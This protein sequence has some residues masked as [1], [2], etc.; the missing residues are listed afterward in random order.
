MCETTKKIVVD[1]VNPYG[2][3]K[4]GIED[5]IVAWTKNLDQNLFDLR[6]MHM[7]PGT[8]YL[9]G[10]KKAYFLTEDKKFV[11]ASY[12]ASGYNLLVNHLGPPDICIAATTPMMSLACEKVRSFN[13]LNYRIFSWIHSEISR[14]ETTGNGGVREM[15][16]A[17]Y[18]LTINSSIADDIKRLKP[19]ACIYN[20]GNPI[21]HEIPKDYDFSLCKSDTL[22][23]VGRLSEEKRIDIILEA[24]AK[25]KHKWNLRIIGDGPIR[26]NIESWI[27]TLRL[28]NQVSILGWKDNPLEY[29]KDVTALVAAS[30][31]EGFMIT[32][33]E[34]LA[35]G[36]TVIST[37]N[38][39]T[40]DYISDGI[41]GYF[42]DSDNSDSLAA[43][44][45][46][47]A[48]GT[49]KI[50]SPDVCRHSVERY[51]KTNYFDD[52][53]RIFLD[54]FSKEKELR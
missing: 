31:Y 30:D 22:A 52:L 15:L 13:K 34:A 3:H 44:L 39:G 42:F 26:A 5:V 54:V 45:N 28:N 24:I 37:K 1:I 18:H 46:K 25:S 10:Y 35:M 27:N 20:I 50:P 19:Q 41:N 16:S 23:Y 49:Y 29:M 11:D 53:K 48:D 38:Q 7:T 2:G 40:R 36:K 33:V 8:E 21:S 43:L 17:A 9:N 32:G 12:C 47:I 4:G 14:Y 6:I 51:Q